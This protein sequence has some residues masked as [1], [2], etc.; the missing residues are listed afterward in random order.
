VAG[1]RIEAGI[2]FRWSGWNVADDADG[3]V[4]TAEKV[5]GVGP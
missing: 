2:A 1:Q 3:P 5:S 4:F